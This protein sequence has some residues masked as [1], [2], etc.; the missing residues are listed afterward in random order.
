MV[1]VAHYLCI[2]YTII[3]LSSIARLL[4]CCTCKII[5]FDDVYILARSAAAT[6]VHT[7]Y[8]G[9]ACTSVSRRNMIEVCEAWNGGMQAR[10]RKDGMGNEA[11]QDKYV[12]RR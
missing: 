4:S 3:I 9:V 5:A 2:L 7:Q 11:M 8:Y 12:A 10:R 6:W 1:G